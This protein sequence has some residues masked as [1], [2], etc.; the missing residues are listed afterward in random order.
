MRKEYPSWALEQE[1][2]AEE[3]ANGADA[4]VREL[5]RRQHVGALLLEDVE[6]RPCPKCDA[7]EGQACI[8]RRGN[9]GGPHIVRKKLSPFQ[10]N[11]ER[12]LSELQRSEVAGWFRPSR[13]GCETDRQRLA[14]FIAR[15]ASSLA[16]PDFDEAEARGPRGHAV[17]P[18]S[19]GR[20]VRVSESHPPPGARPKRSPAPA[21]PPDGPGQ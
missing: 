8:T 14:R 16:P 5:K 4:R 6:S 10:K 1:E 17:Q 12:E 3:F 7:G 9:P 11:F 2:R 13:G 21:S 19:L 15:A 20:P 18:D